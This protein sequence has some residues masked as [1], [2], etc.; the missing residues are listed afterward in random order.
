MLSS[1]GPIKKKRSEALSKKPIATEG[2]GVCTQCGLLLSVRVD[3]DLFFVS[4][5]IKVCAFS[6]VETD[7][8]VG[9]ENLIKVHCF[10]VV[11]FFK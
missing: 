11:F 5:P 6:H 1:I 3:S 2:N 8:D 10:V 7:N 9:D 4:F